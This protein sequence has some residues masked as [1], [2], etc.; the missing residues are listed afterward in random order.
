MPITSRTRQRINVWFPSLEMPAL[1]D[2]Q[3]QL[4]HEGPHRNVLRDLGPKGGPECQENK[5]EDSR[6]GLG[7]LKNL[8][9]GSTAQDFWLLLA[10]NPHFKI[11][12]QLGAPVV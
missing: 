7:W 4:C 1:D 10:Q 5:A 8:R 3:C 2:G 12:L 9:K 6:N 11:E